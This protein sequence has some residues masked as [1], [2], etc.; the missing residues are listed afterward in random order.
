M[1]SVL[2]SLLVL[3]AF[4]FTQTLSFAEEQRVYT[5]NNFSKLLNSQASVY[6]L[7]AGTASDAQNVRGNQTY[8]GLAKRSAMLTSFTSGAHTI[9]GLHRYYKSDATKKL[10]GSGSTFLYRGDD[11]AGT[12][13]TKIKTGLT[14]GARVQFVTY[15]DNVIAF[16]NA[17][18]PVKYD[19][20]T[21]ITDNTAGAR[22]ANELCAQIG[23]PF[24]KLAT[25]SNLDAS[26]WYMYKI[27]WYDGTTYKYSNAKSNP[28][29]TGSSVRAIDLTDIPLGPA[30]TTQ[31]I[32]YRTSG[33]STQ[34]NVEASTTY[35]RLT[36]IA[37]NTATTFSDNVTDATIEADSAPTRATAEAGTNVTPPIGAYPLIHEDHLFI[38]GNPTN[39][40]DIFWSDA[41]NPNYFDPAAYEPVRPDDG[42]VITFMRLQLGILTIGKTNTIQKAYTDV[43]Q[44]GVYSVVVDSPLSFVGCPAPYSVA[45]TPKGLFYLARDG[46]YIFNGQYSTLASD[47]VTPEIRDI[48]TSNIKESSGFYFKQEYHLAYTS[49]SSGSTTN[50]RVLVYDQV[51]DSWVKDTKEI[52]TFTAFDAGTDFGVLYMGSAT[53]DGKVYADEGAPS[54]LLKRYSSEIDLGTFDDVANYGTEGTPTIELAWD[55][56]IDNWSGGT[57]DDLT[58]DIDRPTTTGTWV[59]P[60]FQINADGLVLLYWNETLGSTG[61]VTFAIRSASTSGGIAAA[62][63]SSEFTSPSGSDVSGLTAN[64]FTQIRIS[65]STTDID[66]T[67]QIFVSSGYLFKMDYTKSGV[68]TET[69]IFSLWQSG[70][71]D[72]DVKGY[73]KFIHRFKVF[74]S[75]TS[76]TM[77]FNY[78]NDEGD[79]DNSFTIDLSVNPTTNVVSAGEYDHYEGDNTNKI[80]T[81]YPPA[82]SETT[83]SAIGHYF[84]FKVTE[85]GNK[86]WSLRNVELLY[87]V[88][89]IF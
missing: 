4:L 83:R 20:H 50:N 14:D 36:T 58:G 82:N 3:T 16:N 19:G 48:L 64:L 27:A 73:K 56:T 89:P 44:N 2:K 33:N 81:F 31:R 29:L 39:Q 51:R 43:N 65:L 57:I 55:L 32:I 63:Y 74:Y 60:I 70:W 67:P 71:T 41:F 8:L 13:T 21:V 38:A 45:N 26:G 66:F 10:I 6:S 87:T 86:D 37:N 61:N 24:A 7:P 40:S 1:V 85:P 23:A 59:S 88:Q 77:T 49:S 84:M 30:G 69:S 28:I 62:S 34:A 47:A 53:T 22:T 78:K 17:D 25:G 46:V 79:V 68:T 5:I 42:D 76:G 75:G 52:K 72:L 18:S 9:T 11:D 54:I 80:F 12:L 35:Y 15:K